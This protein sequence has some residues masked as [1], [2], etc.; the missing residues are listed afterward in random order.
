MQAF[1][2]CVPGTRVTIG[3]HDTDY[4]DFPLGAGDTIRL[5]IYEL[6]SDGTLKQYDWNDNTFKTAV[7]TTAFV[8]MT[9]RTTS[10]GGYDTGVYTAQAT[11]VGGFMIGNVYL[12][13]VE[14]HSTGDTPLV[15]PFVYARTGGALKIE[16]GGIAAAAIASGALAAAKFAADVDVYDVLV[17]MNRDSNSA[18]D[19]W[20]VSFVKNG[21]HFTGTVTSPTLA[22]TNRSDGSALFSGAALTQVGSTGFYKVDKSTTAR[23]ALGETGLA[24]VTATIGG[25]SRTFAALPYRDG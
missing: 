24:I 10:G 5:R 25:S 23:L 9:H 13:Q 15:V 14:N 8:T 7:P 20:T 19:E 11:S 2:E 17:A 16:D 12:A 3:L 18:T 21:A 6:Q 4:T 1:V 22:V